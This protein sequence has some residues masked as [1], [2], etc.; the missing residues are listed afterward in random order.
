MTVE[1]RDPSPALRW[2]RTPGRRAR[3]DRDIVHHTGGGANLF[4]L[5]IQEIHRW[6]LANGWAGFAY[7]FYVRLTGIIERG[8][9]ID[10][11]GGHTLN[12]NATTIGICFE[13]NYESVHRAM[14]DAQFNAG[15]WLIRHLRGLYGDRPI[16]G[17]REMS[18][19][20]TDCPGRFFPLSEL[21]TLQY[22]GEEE[23]EMTEAQVRALVTSMLSERLR[24][25]GTTPSDW[26]EA[27]LSQAITAGLTDGTRP[28]GYATREE[29]ALMALR[30][31]QIARNHEIE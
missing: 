9:Q 23:E 27:E 2:D 14:P 4:P 24:G 8:R 3:T 13:G 28:G 18:G 7:H 1:I 21:R 16:S 26:A 12:H 5:S 6:H 15:V 30:A 29:T 22:R 17:H 11:T 20:N 25:N 19:N 10:W 31:A